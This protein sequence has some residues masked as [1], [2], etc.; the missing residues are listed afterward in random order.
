MTHRESHLEFT[1]LP[2]LTVNRNFPAVKLDKRFCQSK[3]Y[4]GTLGIDFISLKETV[5]NMTAIL[6]WKPH[7]RESHRQT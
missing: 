4:S 2:F 6:L 1:P 5:E 3:T 7:N